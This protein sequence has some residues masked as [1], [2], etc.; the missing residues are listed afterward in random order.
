MNYYTLG[1]KPIRLGTLASV[2]THKQTNFDYKVYTVHT[3]LYSILKPI[4]I[5]TLA[6]KSCSVAI[7]KAFVWGGGLYCSGGGGEGGRFWYSIRIKAFP[8]YTYTPQ[9]SSSLRFFSFTLSSFF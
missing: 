1:K 9:R 4:T 6:N 3:L 7:F 2:L 8:W 5:I